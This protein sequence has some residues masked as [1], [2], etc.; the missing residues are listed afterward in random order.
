VGIDQNRL[1]AAIKEVRAVRGLTQSQLAKRIG[2][3]SFV[4]SR[5]ERGQRSVATPTLNA[6]ADALAIPP[7]C[8]ALLG[9]RC[10]VKSK[11]L[12]DFAES[13]RKLISILIV[14]QRD[15]AAVGAGIKKQPAKKALKPRNRPVSEPARL[16]GTLAR[17]PA[18]GKISKSASH[19][20][21]AGR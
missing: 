20:V 19:K 15:M 5:I 16:A 7:G 4:V 8:L 13:L 9:F 12:A 18:K 14:A 3:S 10:S 21:A 1:A 17:R 11:P 2:F 6:I